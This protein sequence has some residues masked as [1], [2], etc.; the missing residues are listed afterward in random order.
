MHAAMSRECLRPLGRLVTM[1]L[2]MVML[3]HSSLADWATHGGH[4][5]RYFSDELTFYEAREKC[6]EE[7]AYLV[8]IDNYLENIFIG[9]LRPGN[10]PE[11]W[12][13]LTT[14]SQEGHSLSR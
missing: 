12:I 7:G 8:S 13:G 11:I 4:E 3:A 1:V 2:G 10:K 14:K 9:D 6:A 5:Y